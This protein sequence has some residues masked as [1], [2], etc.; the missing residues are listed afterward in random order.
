MM[1]GLLNQDAQR[2]AEC[3]FQ[4]TL[5]I[6]SNAKNLYNQFIEMQTIPAQVCCLPQPSN[7]DSR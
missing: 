5:A 2:A 7:F 4:S 1:W 3:T 6:G